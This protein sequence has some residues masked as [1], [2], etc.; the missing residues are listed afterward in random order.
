MY[1]C[2]T[3]SS[4]SSSDEEFSEID[5]QYPDDPIG[6]SDLGVENWGKIVQLND[7]RVSSSD[8]TDGGERVSVLI[9]EYAV[10]LSVSISWI[11]SFGEGFKIGDIDLKDVECFDE[12][13][14][15]VMPLLVMLHT[16]HVL[17]HLVALLV[18]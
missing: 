11:D 10:S 13:L 8:D 12:C 2:L 14:T 1:F 7:G 18:S 5:D 15:Q 9:G 16:L 6:D 17:I 3:L 4:F